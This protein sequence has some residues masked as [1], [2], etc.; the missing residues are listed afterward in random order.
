MIFVSCK[1]L[2]SLISSNSFF[3]DSIYEIMSSAERESFALGKIYMLF[4]SLSCSISITKTSST[5]LNTSTEKGRGHSCFIPDFRRKISVLSLL[6]TMGFYRCPLSDWENFLLIL[7]LW[8][9]CFLLWKGLGFYHMYFF[10]FL[11]IWYITS[12]LICWT[13]LAFLR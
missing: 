8:S 5:M 12:F 6:M 9:E 1:L 3:V 2:N 4:I 7:F 11:L 10:C 13:N